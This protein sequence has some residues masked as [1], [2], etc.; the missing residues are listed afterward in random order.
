MHEWL[1]HQLLC[2]LILLLARSRKAEFSL[3]R[4]RAGAVDSHDFAGNATAV[5][6]LAHGR[7]NRA[8]SLHEELA[9]LGI[10]VVHCSLHD[11][12]GVRIAQHLLQF[13]SAEH[14]IDQN[15]ASV[16]IGIAQAFLDDIRAELLLG[17]TGN[18]PLE[19]VT[20]FRDELRITEVENVLNNVIAVGVLNE[21]ECMLNDLCNEAIPLGARSMIDAALNNT[22]TVTVS[23]DAHA[24][25]AD[26]LVDEVSILSLE[27]VETL[28]N[29]MVAIQILHQGNH[30]VLEGVDDGLNLLSGGDAL[31]HLLQRSGSVLVDGDILQSGGGIVDQDSSLLIV[32]KF[33][34]L[35]AQ[36][37]AKGICESVS[38]R[39]VSMNGSTSVSYQS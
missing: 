31:D 9:R 25:G 26:G 34:Q 24:V 22:A 1:S 8:D 35:L 19:L 23:A 2:N 16:L 21:E 12:I 32:G 3:V 29:N 33:E 36:V 18:A 7:E 30:M 6:G 10:S 17:Q 15:A 5:R 20:D 4:I 13:M 28:L 27:V 39:L 11:V 37:I 38:I 14:F